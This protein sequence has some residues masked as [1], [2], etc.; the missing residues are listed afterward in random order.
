[1]KSILFLLAISIFGSCASFKSDKFVDG[2][3]E[4]NK[5]NLKLINGKY[6]RNPI[7]WD[8]DLFWNFYTRGYNVGTQ[9]S[10]SVD[11]RLIDQKHL[12]VTLMQNDSII[13]SKVLK[14][15]LKNGYFE[16]KRR[17]FIAPAIFFNIFR[18][19]KFR[20]GI[21]E[22]GNLTTDYL[23]KAWGTEFVI[24]PFFNKEEE[25]DYE[26]KKIN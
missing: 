24:F 3:I 26:Y 16:M 25:F 12:T 8:G 19:I 2:Q 5:E 20:F 17:V 18:T 14:G 11:L 9:S 21:L 22:N 15:K 4:L 1:M 6:T 23:Q 7:N 13:K 10:C